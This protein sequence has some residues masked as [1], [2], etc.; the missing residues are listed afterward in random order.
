MILN[1]LWGT[2][3]Y[4]CAH[5][6]DT[7][8]DTG[9]IIA[10]CFY[11]IPNLSYPIDVFK[12]RMNTYKYLLPLALDNLNN[13]EFIPEKQ[14][15]EKST[16][17]PRLKTV[18]DGRINFAEFTGVELLK[19][20]YAFSY[21]YD[22]A[23]CYLDDLKINILECEFIPGDGFHKFTTGIIIGKDKNKNYKIALRDGVLLIKKIEVDKQQIPQNKIFKLGKRLT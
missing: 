14:D 10:K 11:K 18:V 2:E 22:G 1:G 17:F 9:D 7:G 4:G 6:I 8:I 5:Y 15:Y 23:H 13:P 20:I 19:F 21:P 3:Q 16:F 12:A